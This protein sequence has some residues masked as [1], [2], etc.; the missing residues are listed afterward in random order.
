MKTNPLILIPA[1]EISVRCPKKNHELLEWTINWLGPQK[2]NTVL[3]TDSQ[4]L[5]DK[6]N[7][8]DVSTWKTINYN[9][10][11]SCF[12]EYLE[13]NLFTG[14]DFIYL[15]LT[16]PLREIG[17]LDRILNADI[18]DYD[19]ITS[20]TYLPDRSIFEINEDNEFN[21]Q[22]TSGRK[23]CMCSNRKILD[24]A[25]YRIKID[26]LTNTVRSQNQNKTFWDG[27]KGLVSNNMPFLD[28]DTVEDL[29]KFKNLL[30]L[31]NTSPSILP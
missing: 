26:H 2:S 21:I 15:P 1:K 27:K 3:I 17:L 9:G 23:G 31:F 11:F 19:F 22:S 14:E 25:I 16:Q 18:L 24:G 4:E 8:L 28:I 7:L 12:K 13:N 20:Y 5:I 30:T 10:E 29:V 6:A